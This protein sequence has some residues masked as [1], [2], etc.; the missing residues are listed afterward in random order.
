MIAG[1][2][3]GQ[4]RHNMDGLI[5][6]HGDRHGIQSLR[7]GVR[8]LALY[9]PRTASVTHHHRLS[10]ICCPAGGTFPWFDCLHIVWLVAQEIDLDEATGS[11]EQSW[12]FNENENKRKH[13]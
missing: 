6:T 10:G 9:D 2:Q 11:S 1:R 8:L 12:Y 13:R 3:I 5:R 7:T 4:P